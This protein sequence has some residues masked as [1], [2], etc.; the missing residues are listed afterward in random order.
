LYQKKY[1]K[2]AAFCHCLLHVLV[3][4]GASLTYKDY[5]DARAVTH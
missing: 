4:I 1:V 5:Y 3:S 2:S